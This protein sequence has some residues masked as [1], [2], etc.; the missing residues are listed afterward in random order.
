MNIKK[1][2]LQIFSKKYRKLRKIDKTFLEMTERFS[3]LSKCVSKQVACLIVR[4]NRIISSGINGTA[5]G[6]TNCNEVF[7]R[8]KF[9]REKHHIFSDMFEIHA[10]M[11][12]ILNAAK[13][14]ISINNSTAY[15]ILEPCFNC[16]KNLAMSGIRRIVYLN[17]YDLINNNKTDIKKRNKYLKKLKVKLEK[18]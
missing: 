13:N 5:T 7:D 14:G 8:N 9:D 1:S 10:E 17:S 11:N 3:S 12:A 4:D 6:Y 15:C 16:S 2:L 18:Y